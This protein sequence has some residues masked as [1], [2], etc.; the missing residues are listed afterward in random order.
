M[1]KDMVDDSITPVLASAK[2]GDILKQLAQFP[3]MIEAAANAR[4]PYKVAN[5]I[6][7][8]AQLIHEYYAA[9][10]I[11][12]RDDKASTASRLSL[13]KACRIVLRNALALLGVSAPD[14]M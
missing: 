1:G 6:Q 4:A 2:E 7:K 5:Y 12:D 11:I 8:L 10:K 3:S 14:K 13:I 9:T